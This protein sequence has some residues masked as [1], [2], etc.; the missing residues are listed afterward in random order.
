MDYYQLLGISKLATEE[1]IKKGYKR[2]AMKYHPDKNKND[3]DAEQKFKEIS[4]AYQV[5][6]DKNKRRMYD[7]TGKMDEQPLFESAE[8]IFTKLFNIATQTDYLSSL[9]SGMKQS[10]HQPNVKSDT[11]VNNIIN[12]MFGNLAE[13]D[14]SIHIYSMPINPQMANNT[15]IPI[16]QQNNDKVE[17]RTED[18]YYNIRASLEDIYNK[19]TKKI[20]VNHYRKIN[21][22]YRKMPVELEIDLTRRELIFEGMADEI[23]GY[24]AGNI[25][26]NIYD[27]LHDKY[28]RINDI[29]LVYHQDITINQIYNGYKYVIKHL[30]NEE[31]HIEYNAKSLINKNNMYQLIKGKGLDNGDLYIHYVIKFPNE[32]ME[33]LEKDDEVIFNPE[34]NIIVP[35]SVDYKDVHKEQ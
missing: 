34:V 30:N 32:I 8:D 20:T 16:N 3:K 27:K 22:E 26:V 9:F 6:I 12:D 7:L 13:D 11:Y 14:I 15:Y 23:E 10:S 1:E 18:V 29:D 5:L 31:L 2:M 35:E 28:Q 17:K 24:S 21:N 25:I 4:Q 19:I 33:I